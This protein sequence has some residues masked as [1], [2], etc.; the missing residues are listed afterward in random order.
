MQN[1][2]IET[3]VDAFLDECQECIKLLN[4]ISIEN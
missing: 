2:N 4:N 1:I 3:P